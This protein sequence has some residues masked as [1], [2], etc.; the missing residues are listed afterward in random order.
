MTTLKESLSISAFI[1]CFNEIGNLETMVQELL[2]VLSNLTAQYELIIIND[3]SRDGTGDLADTLAKSNEHL[4]VIHHP[5]NLG[6]GYTLRSGFAAA[7]YDWTFFT[8]ADR[9]FNVAELNRF[10]PF[11][12]TYQVII[13]YRKTRAEG[14]MRTLNAR[15][16]HLF[17]DLLFRVHVKDIDCAFK[18]IRS[19]LIKQITFTSTGALISAELLYK[20]K[21]KHLQFKQL[22]VNHYPRRFGKS[23]GANPKVI[24]KAGYEAVKLYLHL[25]FG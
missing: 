21:K 11:T 3:G 8:D 20:L 19:D 18:L 15:L 16:Y 12:K 17:I 2:A 14:G 10:I 22:P 5:K 25:K 24:L 9:Q 4:K 23:T 7:R 1:P 6:Y 13:G